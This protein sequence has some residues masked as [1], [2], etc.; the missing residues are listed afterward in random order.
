MRKIK[1]C[2]GCGRTLCQLCEENHSELV[3]K[4]KFNGNELEVC[5]S[6]HKGGMGQ[7][8]ESGKVSLP[9]P[10]RIE[11]SK[12]ITLMVARVS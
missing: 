6:C 8:S 2:P 12:A 9:T 4:N 3:M 7:M 10:E 11:K 1:K 5:K